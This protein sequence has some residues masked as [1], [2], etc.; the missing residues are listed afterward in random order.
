MT[1]SIS[2]ML[3]SLLVIVHASLPHTKIEEYHSEQSS[4]NQGDTD[5]LAA[6]GNGGTGLA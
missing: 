5:P 1:E 4:T 6:Q 3:S 2:N